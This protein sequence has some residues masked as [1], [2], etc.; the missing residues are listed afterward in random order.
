[1]FIVIVINRNI[2]ILPIAFFLGVAN[3]V[4]SYTM[5]LVRLKEA[6]MDAKEISFITNIDDAITSTLGQVF[7]NSY[8]DYCC[9]S[10]ALYVH[11]R[12]GQNITFE[13]F[14]W[15]TCK[16]YTMSVFQETFC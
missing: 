11:T 15:H 14:F 4:D 10:V 13:P 8:N 16:S 1:M 5:F 6:F 3:N 7:P 2:Q 9:M 12:D